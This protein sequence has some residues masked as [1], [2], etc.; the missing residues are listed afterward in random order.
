VVL[1]RK[2]VRTF[3]QLLEIAK[4]FQRSARRSYLALAFF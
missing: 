2:Q 1:L 3:S 4:Y